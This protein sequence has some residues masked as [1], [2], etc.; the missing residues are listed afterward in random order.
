MALGISA[1]DVLHLKNDSQ[2]WWNGPD[3]KRKFDEDANNSFFLNK[4][5]DVSDDHIDKCCHYEY[6]FL[7]G[8]RTQYNGLPIKEVDWGAHD[9]STTYWDEGWQK[10]VPIPAGYTAP[11]RVSPMM[12]RMNWG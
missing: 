10:M 12:M 3:A 6:L 4:S 11:P 8:G 7:D 9:D 5:R 1:S 2:K